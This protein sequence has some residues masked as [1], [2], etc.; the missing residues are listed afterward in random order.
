MFRL[1]TKK[2]SK[3]QTDVPLLHIFT[4]IFYLAIMNA[5][6]A[7]T[8]LWLNPYISLIKQNMQLVKTYFLII[9]IYIYSIIIL[10]FD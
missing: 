2:L 5:M 10:C 8:K 6:L 1:T 3:L 7:V 9:E 4:N